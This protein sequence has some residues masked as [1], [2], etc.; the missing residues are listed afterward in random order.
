M[1][2]KITVKDK[3]KQTILWLIDIP[4]TVCIWFGGL[5]MSS[6]ISIVIDNNT[7]V[8]IDNNT[9][10]AIN[11]LL[12]LY[13]FVPVFIVITGYVIMNIFKIWLKSH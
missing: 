4:L 1:K 8:G 7:S 2:N 3:I 13:I 10:S 5:K 11:T 9:V 12:T 6:Y